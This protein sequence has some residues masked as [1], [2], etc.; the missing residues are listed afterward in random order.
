MYYIEILSDKTGG[1]SSAHARINYVTGSI[2]TFCLLY[3]YIVYGVSRG[4]SA[5]TCTAGT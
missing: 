2:S 5:E 1:N 3:F 4:F